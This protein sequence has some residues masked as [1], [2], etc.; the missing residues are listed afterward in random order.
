MHTIQEFWVKVPPTSEEVRDMVAE[1]IRYKSPLELV[2]LPDQEVPAPEEIP[3][4]FPMRQVHL[5]KDGRL[6][7]EGDNE[8]YDSIVVRTQQADEQPARASIVIP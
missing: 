7:I 8:N 5:F 3:L 1:A 6:K 4:V 2:I